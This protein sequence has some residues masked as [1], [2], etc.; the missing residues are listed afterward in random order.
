MTFDGPFPMKEGKEWS[1]GAYFFNY[2]TF[3][4]RDPEGRYRVLIFSPQENLDT[5]VRLEFCRRPV[6]QL[7]VTTGEPME[8]TVMM[9]EQDT[10]TVEILSQESLT[11]G[12]W[13]DVA[14]DVVTE[15]AEE[16]VVEISDETA[17]IVN[18]IDEPTTTIEMRTC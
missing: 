11:I 12:T 8:V 16:Q 17:I 6:Q 9:P 14:I 2:S 15:D 1:A 10:A 4:D 13:A 7:E 5:S 3:P 18:A